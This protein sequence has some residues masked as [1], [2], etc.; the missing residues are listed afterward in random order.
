MAASMIP[1]VLERQ[2]FTENLFNFAMVR[3]VTRINSR[4]FFLIFNDIIPYLNPVQ[5]PCLSASPL[6]LFQN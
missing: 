1:Y 4:I 2:Q 3:G 5:S 6:P